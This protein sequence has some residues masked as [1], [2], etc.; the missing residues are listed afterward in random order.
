MKPL[1]ITFL[2]ISSILSAQNFPKSYEGTWKGELNIYNSSNE[3]PSMRVPMQLIIQPKN[4][5]VWSWEIHYL[6]DKPDIRRYE[7]VHDLKDGLWKIDEKNGIVL[8]QTFLN[9]RM[10]SVFSLEN[11]ML[12]AS[13]WLENDQ[14]NFEITVTKISPEKTTGLR[15]EE[16][17]EVGIHSVSS[18]HKAILITQ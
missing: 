2:F 14:M 10:K 15:N 18:Y 7:L 12:I 13:Y 1:L 11:T 4:D 6:M 3:N 8:P 16:S 5:S 17:P 9:G